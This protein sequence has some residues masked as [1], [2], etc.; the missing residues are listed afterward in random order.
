MSTLSVTL[1]YTV[2]AGVTKFHSTLYSRG[3]RLQLYTAVSNRP[4]YFYPAWVVLNQRSD[5]I[6]IFLSLSNLDVDSLI[7]DTP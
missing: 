6:T 3:I 1:K 7:N 4:L 5:Q 2:A